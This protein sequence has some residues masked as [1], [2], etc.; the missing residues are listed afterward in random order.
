VPGFAWLP[1]GSVQLKGKA[2]RLPIH[3]LVGSTELARSPEFIELS[4]A[5]AELFGGRGDI[6][7]CQALAAAVEPR[8]VRFYA[9]VPGRADDF[10]SPA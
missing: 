10:G 1:A 6:A 4:K 5:H 7:R 3:I 8:L 2:K 9:F